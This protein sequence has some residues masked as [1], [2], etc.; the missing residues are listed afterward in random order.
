MINIIYAGNKRTF[1]GI[2]L[3]AISVAKRTKEEVTFNVLTM[4]VSH[5]NKAFVP[6]SEEQINVIDKTV[7]SISNKCHAKLYR[8]DD[9][10]KSTLLGNKNEKASYTPYAL[11]RLLIDKIPDFKGKVIY[12]DVDTMATGDIK[13]L[14]DIDV[15]DYE[16]AACRDYLGKFWINPKYFNSGVLLMN[17]DKMRE[18]KLLEKVIN[19]IRTKHLYFVDQSALNKSVKY[20]KYFP[21]EFRFN[22]Q[23]DIKPNTVVKHFCQGI[24]WK[25]F[26]HVYN[27]KQWDINA[28]HS[29]L[30]IFDFD[31]DYNIYKKAKDEMNPD[32]LTV[33]HLI[34][35][36]G[37]VKA[38]NDISFKVKRGSLFAFL[39]VNGAGKSTTI[40]I[41]ASIL[42]KDQG[43]VTVDGLDLDASRAE[44][45]KRI[46]IVF[47]NSVLDGDLTVIDNLRT[48]ASFYPSTK[49][50]REQKIQEL[51]DILDLKAILKRRVGRLSGGQRRRVDIARSMLHSPELLILDEPTTGLDPKTRKDVWNL[52][53]NIR[54][55][56][57]MSVFLTTHYL[58]E[59]DQASDVVIMDHGNIIATGTP[60]ELKNKYSQNYVI[61]YA[62]ESD[63]M[64]EVL[65]NQKYTY[66][67]DSL[68][69]HVAFKTTNEAADFIEKNRKDIKDFEVKKGD[70]D[71][72]FLNVTG[73]SADKIEEE[74]END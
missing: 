10:Y 34:K 68:S 72:V 36:Y 14:Y 32:I 61:I 26:F 74:Q 35:Q 62:S 65:K 16:L 21:D 50:E 46:G 71:D 59:A 52:I 47:Q 8:C 24:K 73:R 53:D 20:L 43:Q 45:K 39:G 1:D 2:L 19:L 56:K 33:D 48:R 17:L 57:N 12:L 41:I 3:S 49:E 37:D 42:S 7:N 60:T 5:L 44:V 31:D 15:K 6:I 22:E 63:H 38:V 25:P 18:T 70:M 30:K 40:N 58:E 27:I 9:L 64:N 55:E 28:V 13:E 54:K 69:Y 67:Q 66:H 11:L 23:R 29:R 4:D 51:I